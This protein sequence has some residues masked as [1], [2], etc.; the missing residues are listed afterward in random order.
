MTHD[1][2]NLFHQVPYIL[3]QVPKWALQVLKGRY[4]GLHHQ[5]NIY[6]YVVTLWEA[7]TGVHRILFGVLQIHYGS[8]GANTYSSQLFTLFTVVSKFIDRSITLTRIY[9]H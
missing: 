6:T 2:S 8:C 3:V 9:K 4:R 7:F 5:N 1:P